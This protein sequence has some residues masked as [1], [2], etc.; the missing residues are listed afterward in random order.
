MILYI[1]ESQISVCV[2]ECSVL[3]TRIQ[4]VGEFE[5][6]TLFIAIYI[7]YII[8]SSIISTRLNNKNSKGAENLKIYTL[9][10]VIYIVYIIFFSNPFNKT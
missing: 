10:I 8:F 5:L 9:F 1:H 4:K 3:T 7:A 6:H 2:D